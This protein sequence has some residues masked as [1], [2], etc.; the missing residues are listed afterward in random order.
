MEVLLTLRPTQTLY[1]KF[2][3]AA[4]G[5]A[6]RPKNLSKGLLYGPALRSDLRGLLMT[7]SFQTD[8]R[9]DGGV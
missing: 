1:R 7:P 8:C 9:K 4:G 2:F 3:P 6:L 5:S